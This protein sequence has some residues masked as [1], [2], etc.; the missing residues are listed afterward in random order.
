M[1]ER[2]PG[3]IFAF[4]SLSPP[5]SRSSIEKVELPAFIRVIEPF[6][7]RA[8]VDLSTACE[9]FWGSSFEE[10]SFRDDLRPARRGRTAALPCGFASFLGGGLTLG[11][12][13]VCFWSGEVEAA[14]EDG[15]DPLA[16]AR[17]GLPPF[18][19]EDRP[20]FSFLL[21]EAAAGGAPLGGS[22]DVLG[23]PGLLGGSALAVFW[24]GALVALL[25]EAV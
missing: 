25:G 20:S 18:L 5:P 2:P 8:A 21:G 24:A 12:C 3:G 22:A 17:L 6:F 10:D 7:L 11:C 9:L 1:E 13:L 23:A 16:A 14:A 15:R 4:A 19:G